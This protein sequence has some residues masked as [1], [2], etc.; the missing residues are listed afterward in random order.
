[1]LPSENEAIQQHAQEWAK[2]LTRDDRLSL[3]LLPHDILVRQL[4][5]KLRNAA[6]VIV[7]VRVLII[8]AVTIPMQIMF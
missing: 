1:M 2:V 4:K 6:C 3:S 8:A 5:L 7:S